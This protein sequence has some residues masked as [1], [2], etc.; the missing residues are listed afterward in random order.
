MLGRPP[1]N[2]TRF[3][4]ACITLAERADTKVKTEIMSLQ[5]KIKEMPSVAQQLHTIP[6]HHFKINNNKNIMLNT[7]TIEFNSG[8]ILALWHASPRPDRCQANVCIIRR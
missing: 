1:T 4:T 5:A 2:A 8:A 6:L 3:T 7:Q